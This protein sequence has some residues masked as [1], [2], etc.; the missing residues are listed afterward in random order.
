MLMESLPKAIV[1]DRDR[2]VISQ[3]FYEPEEVAGYFA[4]S[5]GSY[6]IMLTNKECINVQMTARTVQLMESLMANKQA[7]Q[8]LV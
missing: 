8:S 1:L 6:T 7:S 5:D 4:N 2:L 3:K